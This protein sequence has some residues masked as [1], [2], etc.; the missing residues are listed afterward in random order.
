MSSEILWAKYWWGITVAWLNCTLFWGSSAS[1]WLQWGGVVNGELA[2]K[3]T[4]HLFLD[5]VLSHCPICIFTFTLALMGLAVQ[6]VVC[7]S[8]QGPRGSLKVRGPSEPP[9]LD[10]AVRERALLC[11]SGR[12]PWYKAVSLR[13]LCSH[14]RDALY[15]SPRVGWRGWVRVG[16]GGGGDS[17]L[18]AHC[19]YCHSCFATVVYFGKSYGKHNG[20]PTHENKGQ[21]SSSFESL[22]A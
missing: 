7:A 3:L 15:F 6:C 2:T 8:R 13:S 5:C 18:A 11:D 14:T 21:L 16:D 22:F 1:S 9:W 17:V 10:G 4:A 20:K 12:I 19:L